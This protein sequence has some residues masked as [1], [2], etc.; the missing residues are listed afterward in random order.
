MLSGD[1][2]II[3]INLA[4]KDRVADPPD[5]AEMMNAKVLAPVSGI[6][7]EPT[8]MNL[9]DLIHIN[10]LKGHQDPGMDQYEDNFNHPP[11]AHL[12]SVN[13]HA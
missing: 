4:V 2:N 11:I 3:D 7:T 6:Y 10:L 1:E 8:T 13:S 12:G 5:R 9:G